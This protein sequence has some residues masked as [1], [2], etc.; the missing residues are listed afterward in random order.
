MNII[1]LKKVV[2]RFRDIN[3]GRFHPFTGHE[4]PYG[5]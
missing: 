2:V 4:G 3:I 1:L 5:E